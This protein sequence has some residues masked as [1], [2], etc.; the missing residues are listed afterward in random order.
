MTEQIGVLVVDDNQDLA[1]MF[2]ALINGE[3]DM[4]CTGTLG[5]A[6]ALLET[7]R[8]R[9][10]DVVL[11]DL[12]MPGKDP[13]EALRE[14]VA[15]EGSPPVLVLSGYDDVVTRKRVQDQGAR[16]FVSKQGDIPAILES[17]REVVR[18]K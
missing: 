10:P 4:A 3:P 13:L 16:G 15:E 6:D 12:T 5:S 9:R 1:E 11:L 2:A 7:I 14:I 18:E 17:I 8:D